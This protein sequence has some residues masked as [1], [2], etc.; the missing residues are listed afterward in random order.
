MRP[1]ELAWLPP[2]PLDETTYQTENAIIRDSY[3]YFGKSWEGVDPNKV[4]RKQ[5]RLIDCWLAEL[6]E[7][8]TQ[9]YQL[10]EQY[11]SP[12]DWVAICGDQTCAQPQDRIGIQHN[13]NLVLE[14]DAKDL[15]LEYTNQKLQ[16]IQTML[17]QTDAAGVLDRAGLTQYAARALDPALAQRIV[18][19]QDAVTQ[20]EVTDEQNALG[21]IVS[22]IDPPIYQGGQNAQLRLQVMQS[23]LQSAPDY[24]KML[25]VNPLAMQR[26][27]KRMQA[28]QFQ[29]AQAQNAITGKIGVPP[30]P[31]QNLT[32]VGPA[33]P[34]ALPPPGQP[35]ANT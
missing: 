16:L 23:T 9:I 18:R 4:L 35:A 5:Q 11:M 33:P 24:V 32:G 30:G 26:F 19:P 10:C 3:S 7:V 27:Q 28:F 13:L 31:T 17:V 1:G 20:Q 14:F 34:P 6:R 29:I 12:E 21:N 25:Q 15:N 2:P 22:G 8:Y